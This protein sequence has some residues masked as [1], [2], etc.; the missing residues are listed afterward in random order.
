MQE[1]ILH[2]NKSSVYLIWS[3]GFGV[4]WYVRQVKITNRPTYALDANA[5]REDAPELQN[6]APKV[7]HLFI[8]E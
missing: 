5:F 7:L 1:G 2:I 6:V 3:G 8:H 4:T